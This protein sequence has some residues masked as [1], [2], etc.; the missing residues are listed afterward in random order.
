MTR[1]DRLWLRLALLVFAAGVFAYRDNIMDDTWIHL[2]YARNLRAHGELAFNPG[3]ASLGLTSPLWVLL[4][5]LLGSSETLARLASVGAGALAVWAFAVLAR[6]TLGSVAYAAAATLA[7]AANVWL[8]RHAPNGMESTL[9][10]LLVVL[11]IDLHLQAGRSSL[12]AL[13]LGSALAAAFLTRP[14]AAILIA[15]IACNDLRS[16][17]GRRSLR[18]WAPVCALL[19]GAWLVFASLRTGQML[20]GTAGAKSGAAGDVLA[21]MRVLGREA[22]IVAAAH[23]VELGGML[24]ALA[25]SMRLQGWG[26]LRAILRPPLAVYAAFGLLLLVAFAALDVQVQPRYLLPVL[27]AFVLVG[28]AAWK[29][30]LGAGARGAWTLALL[31]VVVN[32]AV[33]WVR[34]LPPTR[35]FASGLRPAMAPLVEELQARAAPSSRVATPDIGYIGYHATLR[36]LDLGGLIDPQM[37]A[38]RRRIGDTAVLEEGAFLQRGAVD[39]VIDRDLERERFTGH[40]T[41]G[42]RWKPL[43]TTSIANLGLSRPGPYYY[44]LYALERSDAPSSEP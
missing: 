5:A 25:L 35:A 4:L 2:Q 31:C 21:A 32:A 43:R 18:M 26:A 33:S 8:V 20:A 30:V 3:E 1:A 42:L 11:A 16:A 10:V 28:F 39:Y 17:T 29:S 38:L 36:V 44:T 19:C 23:L 12:R 37:L 22:R 7:W 34:V 13:A 14:E 40:V 6:R 9:A 24:A 41:G 15:V 27:P